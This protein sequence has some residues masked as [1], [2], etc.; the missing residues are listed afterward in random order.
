MEITVNNLSV[1]SF[2]K[3]YG[4]TSTTLNIN[5]SLKSEGVIGQEGSPTALYF[6]SPTNICQVSVPVASSP[7]TLGNVYGKSIEVVSSTNR[8]GDILSKKKRPTADLFLANGA[9]QTQNLEILAGTPHLK[10]IIFPS[11]VTLDVNDFYIPNQE[12]SFLNLIIKR[13][14][15]KN[16]KLTYPYFSKGSL[17]FIEEGVNPD[18]TT[19]KELLKQL[20]GQNGDQ[21]KTAHEISFESNIKALSGMDFYTPH[22][23]VIFG[24]ENSE[25]LPTITLVEEVPGQEENQ[26]PLKPK[27]YEMFER[28]GKNHSITGFCGEFDLQKVTLMGDNFTLESPLGYTLGRLIRDQNRDVFATFFSHEYNNTSCNIGNRLCITNYNL[29]GKYYKN[30]YDGRHLLILPYLIQNGSSVNFFNKAHF[31]GP[32]TH[33]AELSTQKLVLDKKS[34]CIASKTK[35]DFLTV[36]SELVLAIAIGDIG[37]FMSSN[38]IISSAKFCS[39]SACECLVDVQ[40]EGNGKISNIGS[41]FYS[42]H[43]DRHINYNKVDI[44]TGLHQ[45]VFD[46]TPNTRSSLK[47][48]FSNSVPPNVTKPIYNYDTQGNDSYA[49]GFL[50]KTNN[51]AG[52]QNFFK[53]SDSSP[54]QTA[55]SAS[56]ALV[57]LEGNTTAPEILIIKKPETTLVVGSKGAQTV[58]FEAP[59]SDFSTSPQTL[60][61][62]LFKINDLSRFL[63]PS[64]PTSLFGSAQSPQSPLNPD[65]T[66]PTFIPEELFSIKRYYFKVTDRYRDTRTQDQEFYSQVE[67]FLVIEKHQDAD[68]AAYEKPPVLGLRFFQHQPGQLLKWVQEETQKK[69]K[70]GYLYP[71]ESMDL[72][73]VKKLHKNGFDF[74][75][76]T[77][78]S[79]ALVDPTT[80]KERLTDPILFYQELCDE[81][82]VLYYTPV[83]YF[84]PKWI[85]ESA[86]GLNTKQLLIL[87]SEMSISEMA[88]TIA[89]HNPKLLKGFIKTIQSSPEM[90]LQFEQEEQERDQSLTLRAPQAASSQASTSQTSQPQALD[91][92]LF[93]GSI[94]LMRVLLWLKET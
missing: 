58:T 17:T 69:L 2:S 78:S 5:Q 43:F 27:T 46:D 23:K 53:A 3:L 92:S 41:I 4:K 65:P 83:L 88:N 42:H 52:A 26:N 68:T 51:F 73:V 76:K 35:V 36:N 93:K 13:A 45:K 86:F 75:L 49:Y 24:N 44:A 30:I 61:T 77:E 32:V 66:T 25:N 62:N 64:T 31:K 91:L 33:Y 10:N 34:T 56:G 19:C 54:Y 29:L 9:F 6:G 57:K 79:T 84:P 7:H 89:H 8:Y 40:T 70:R 48:A 59:R 47:S 21:G 38:T 11:S 81:S 20:Y 12:D 87:S 50:Q 80:F 72:E 37:P 74:L 18:E 15:H 85:L 90:M 16:F 55:Q 28:D 94:K 63:R 14:S 60:N 1:S 39:S 82:D 67:P 22:A 71:Y